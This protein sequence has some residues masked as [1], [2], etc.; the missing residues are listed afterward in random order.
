MAADILNRMKHRVL[1]AAGFIRDACVHRRQ[2]RPLAEAGQSLAI[3]A[4]ILTL[5]AVVSVGAV[6]TLNDN[7]SQKMDLAEDRISNRSPGSE[8]E[9]IH[10]EALRSITAS[11][12]D[13]SGEYDGDSR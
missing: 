4:V 1:S 6:R 2:T 11:S 5:V 13:Y 12:Q 8:Y 7:V 3:Y 9:Y 10:V